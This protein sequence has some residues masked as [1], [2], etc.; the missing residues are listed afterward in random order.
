MNTLTKRIPVLLLALVLLVS[1]LPLG[2]LAASGF[3]SLSSS[4]YCEMIAPAQLSVYQ[5]NAMTTRGTLNPSK[6]YNASVYAGDKIQILEITSSYTVVSYP[7]S[8]GSRIGIVRTSDL[9]GCSAPSEVISSSRASVTTYTGNSTAKVSGSTSVG[10]VVYRLGATKN[11]FILIIYT[12]HSGARAFKAAFVTP[13]DY[14]LVK[15]GKSSGSSSGSGSGSTLT[16]GLYHGSGTI[17]CGFDKYRTTNGRHEG[18]DMSKGIGS[19]VYS[20]TDG[21]VTRVSEGAVGS[22]G[23]S[24]IAI[25]N[26]SADRTVVYLHTDPSDGQY[27]GQTISRGQQIAVESWRGLSSSSSAHTHVEVRTG[28]RTAAAKSVN[29]ST[30][31]NPNPTAFWNSMGYTI[32]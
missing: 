1:A 24:T 7:T 19:A 20:L 12:A 16:Y 27:V 18:I 23:L 31:D 17:T 22:G 4:H 2:A 5:D 28:K 25:Y 15:N 8:S 14:E 30:L 29:D 6:A 11:G 21:V 9:F 32:Q 3:P 26:A 13:S 10:D